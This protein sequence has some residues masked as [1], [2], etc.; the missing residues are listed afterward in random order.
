[1]KAFALRAAMVALALGAVP[2]AV[3]ASWV[4]GTGGSVLVSAPAGTADG[5][6]NYAVYQN[7]GAGVSGGNLFTQLGIAQANDI[8]VGGSAANYKTRQYAYVYQVVNTQY[9]TALEAALDSLFIRANM[10]T[11]SGVAT[12][13][14]GGATPQG[15]VFTE[16]VGG[17]TTKITATGAPTDPT[18]GNNRLDG[19]AAENHT[20]SAPTVT[21][22]QPNGTAVDAGAWPGNP[23]MTAAWN[24]FPDN[25]GNRA[26]RVD[27]GAAS[28]LGTN[29]YTTLIIVT[30]DFAPVTAGLALQDG[31][32]ANGLGPVPTPEPGT[33]A[34]LGLGLPLLGWGYVRRLRANKAV[35]AAVTA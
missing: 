13:S 14:T 16:L 34:L 17:V 9:N 12:A 11:V 5:V 6:I 25:S 28:K 32:N 2:G 10:D 19:G 15:Y 1:M 35:V 18:G 7:D 24:F 31:G 29:M 27:F 3:Q 33:L 23:G 21:T 8:L 22:G 26:I 4:A 30:S 20:N